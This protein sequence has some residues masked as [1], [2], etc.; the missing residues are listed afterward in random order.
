MSKGN[1]FL[2]GARGSVGDVTLQV[3][4][5]QQITKRRNRNPNNPKTKKQMYQRASFAEPVKFF[6][7]GQQNLFKFAFE[8]KAAQES[9]YN[10]F[11]RVN[12]KLG[13][14]M[15]KQ[16]I[17]S[18]FIAKIGNFCLTMGSLTGIAAESFAFSPS[19]SVGGFGVKTS[20]IIDTVPTTF[21]ELSAAILNGSK[22]LQ[23]GD[24]ITLLCIDSDNGISD[25]IPYL[26]SDNEYEPIWTIEQ[27]II[28]TADATPLTAAWTLYKDSDNKLIITNANVST[29][30]EVCGSALIISRNVPGGVKVSTSYIKNSPYAQQAIDAMK[31]NFEN[32][33]FDDPWAAEVLASWSAAGEAI[34]QGSLA[35]KAPAHSFIIS[36]VSPE[37]LEVDE[38][39]SVGRSFRLCY[40]EFDNIGDVKHSDIK[41]VGDLSS[42]NAKYN[43]TITADETGVYGSEIGLEPL[44]G[45]HYSAGNVP[46]SVTIQGVVVAEGYAHFV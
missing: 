45:S 8:N 41:V 4:K 12:A 23:N 25:E 42:L 3:L 18:P 29:T 43:V 32:P 40:I 34:L 38:D 36:S 14:L 33:V 13:V 2:G 7:R 11:M 24:I 46:I 20:L 44:T 16:Q 1:M 22:G 6:T 30:N 5:G 37:S 31:P 39:A 35:P 26:V 19:E 21:G 28:N 27:F 9:D 17:E 10:A 15:T